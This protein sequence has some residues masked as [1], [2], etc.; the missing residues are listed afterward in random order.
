[1]RLISAHD[2]KTGAAFVLPGTARC[3][4]A[5]RA[6]H[7]HEVDHGLDRAFV[8]PAAVRPLSSC[9]AGAIVYVEWKGPKSGRWI[10]LRVV[11]MG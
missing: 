6:H 3:I 7:A 1:M 10:K 8:D 4:E 2:L 5:T 9:A 11:Q